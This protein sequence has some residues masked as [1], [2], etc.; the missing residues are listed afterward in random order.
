MGERAQDP[1]ALCLVAITSHADLLIYKSFCYD[2]GAGDSNDVMEAGVGAAER[3]AAAAA[4]ASGSKVMAETL[5]AM[6]TVRFSKQVHDMMLRGL[7]LKKWQDFFGDEP[8][9]GDPTREA[10]L[11][12]LRT[13]R[14]IPLENV[15]GERGILVAGRH[16]AVVVFGRGFVRVHPWKLELNEGVR[17]AARFCSGA[18]SNDIVCIGDKGEGRNMRGMLKICSLPRDLVLDAYWPVRIK[19]L[20][21][22]VHHVCYHPPSGC[23]VII[24]SV[25]D[26]MDEERKPEGTFEGKV[27][28]LVE[29]RYQLQL[30]APYTLD[31]IDTHVFDYVNGEQALCLQ[32]VHMK[33]TRNP[34]FLLPLIA[35]GTVCARACMRAGMCCTA[36]TRAVITGLG[37]K[38][39]A[40]TLIPRACAHMQGFVNGES[41]AS[42]STG[43]VYVFE[44]SEVVGEEG[45]QGRVS[46]KI[47]QI[48]S[49]ADL[50]DIKA[51]VTAL[52]QLEGYLLVA[53]GP[54]PGMIGGSKLYVY[55]WV[56]EKLV[57][58]AFFDAH[59]YITTLKT[60]KFF[61]IFGD[62][63]H[64]VHLLRWRE[65]IRMLQLLARD[66]MQLSVYATEF[67][68]MGNQL[69]IIASDE[70]RNIQIF[71]F[72]PNSPYYRRQ[73]LIC[74][75]D[76]HVGTHINKFIRWRMPLRPQLGVRLAAHFVTLDG[77]FGCVCPLSQKA[78]QRLLALQTKLETAVP[79]VAGLNP[80][81][82]RLFR[83]ALSMK[84]RYSKNFLDGNLLGRYIHL[85]LGLQLQLASALHQSRDVLLGDL[86]ELLVSTQIT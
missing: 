40:S 41:E 20:S 65:D 36:R 9:L 78:Y 7:E 53:Q 32:L 35:V 1:A 17:S 25:I 27:P 70:Q 26:E 51:P 30:L 74:Q 73:Q 60:I 86:Y 79:H 56:E 55:E 22:T 75:A 19:Q 47:K 80:R 61:I 2:A 54:N 21:C 28:M 62:V 37:E 23:H 46:F 18:A 85:D 38:L 8:E 43:R 39:L 6:Q 11:T 71:I 16:P 13:A 50:Q 72:N 69:G 49:S 67:I 76:L 58:R 83:P 14:L 10:S 3:G 15:N 84:R 59:L 31:V 45:L 29:E 48:F 44:L 68:V 66:P 24:S 57:G 77:A 82:W 34:D 5:R 33:N 42:R 52:C 81:T 63:H 4:A 64:S 12:V